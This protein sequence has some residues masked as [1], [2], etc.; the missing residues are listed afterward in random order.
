MVPDLVLTYNRHEATYD[1]SN[2]QI[3]SVTVQY[4]DCPLYSNT[5]RVGTHI[6]TCTLFNTNSVPAPIGDTTTYNNE[7]VSILKIDNLTIMFNPMINIIKINDK[8]VWP[9]GTYEF[10][11]TSCNINHIGPSGII[12]IVASNSS[13][14][15]VRIYFDKLTQ[16]NQENF[17]HQMFN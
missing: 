3:G 4:L 7:T 12:Q 5:K 1:Y 8:Y 15:L 9:N 14:R 16:V 6:S 10:N 11:F 17:G 13:E 2:S